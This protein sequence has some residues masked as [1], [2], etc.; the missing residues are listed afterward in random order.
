MV[1]RCPGPPRFQGCR[2]EVRIE[3]VFSSV[4]C[5]LAGRFLTA[6]PGPSTARTYPSN[7]PTRHGT[8]GAGFVARSQRG[9][10][11]PCRVGRFGREETA[12]R[13]WYYGRGH[14]PIFPESQVSTRA[15]R[16]Y[17]ERCESGPVDG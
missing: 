7:V 2:L 5:G 3:H 13:T 16:R 6:P 1:V 14:P 10:T 17:R 12:F 9:D 4:K 15:G 8:W 11:V